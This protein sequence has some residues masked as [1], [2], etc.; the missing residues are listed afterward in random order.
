MTGSSALMAIGYIFFC[1]ILFFPFHANKPF[2]YGVRVVEKNKS[3]APPSKCSG[4][5]KG[6]RIAHKYGHCSPSSENKSPAASSQILL[7]DEHRVVYNSY[8]RRTGVTKRTTTDPVVDHSVDTGSYIT[9]VRCQ[10]CLLGSC[11]KQQGNSVYYPSSSSTSSKAPCWPS[12]NY[13]QSY[14]DNSFSS[15]IFVLDTL[16]IE[17][18]DVIP[19]FVFLCA[20]N[21]SQDFGDAAGILGLG[22]GS[23]S[24]ADQ[25]YGNYSLISQTSTKFGNIFCHCLPT[26]ESSTGYLYFGKEALEKCQNSGTYTPLLSNPNN[27]SLYYVNLVAI[28][29]GQ[30]RLEISSAVSSS[31]SSSSPS[32]IIDSGTVITRLPSSVYSALSSEF[33]E[34]MLEYPLAPNDNILHTCYNLTGNETIPNMVLHFENLDVNLDQTAVTWKGEVPSQV[35]LAFAGNHNEDDLTIIGN[36]QLQKLNVLYNIQDQRVQIGPG[37]C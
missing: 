2:V 24:T 1:Y 19:N 27:P 34:L 10:R 15:G 36:H 28:T 33:K 29:I 9:W 21:H 8:N 31:S 35:C 37:N 5:A 32:T 16:L 22:L 3:H 20:E 23:T 6:L 17:P 11:P 14:L 12:C 4:P 30:K 25:D 26:A 7:Q 18:S 13:S